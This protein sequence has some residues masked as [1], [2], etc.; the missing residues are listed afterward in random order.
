MIKTKT[1]IEEINGCNVYKAKD[2]FELTRLVMSEKKGNLFVRT[3]RD[4]IKM[5][6]IIVLEDGENTN[7]DEPHFVKCESG[8]QVG[9]CICSN[10]GE[11]PV[12]CQKMIIDGKELL[13]HPQNLGCDRNVF[14]IT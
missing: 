7:I 14:L 10:I 8:F 5:M 12:E 13:L 6:C 4:D 3:S 1:K 9:W 2:F 11:V